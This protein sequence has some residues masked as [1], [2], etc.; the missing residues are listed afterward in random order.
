[1]AATYPRVT[2]SGW[3]Q[4]S[5]KTYVLGFLLCLVLTLFSFAIVYTGHFSHATIYTLLTLSALGQLLVQSVSFLGLKSDQDGQWNL[6][7]FLFT[8]M[9]IVFLVGG[10]LWIMYNLNMLM[11]TEPFGV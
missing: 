6:L 2:N 9:I 5:V 10:S 11:M 1:M 4:K 7:P 3:S 8:L